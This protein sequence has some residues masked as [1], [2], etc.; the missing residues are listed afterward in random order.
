MSESRELNRGKWFLIDFIVL[1][2]LLGID[3]YTKLLTLAKLKGNA[4]FVIFKGVLELDFVANT[5]SAFGLF[6]DKKIFLLLTGA[7][8][9]AAVIFVVYRIPAQKKYRLLHIA[10]TMIV[11]GGVGNM[12]DRYIYGYVVDFIS[13]IL[14]NYPVFNFADICIVLAAI[15]VFILFIFVYKDSDL[16][17]LFGSKKKKEDNQ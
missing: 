6:E 13:F 2:V 10:L 11:A 5:G 17:F 12:I 16:A 8:F 1:A 4:P 3:R 9:M 14:I 15:C 7:I